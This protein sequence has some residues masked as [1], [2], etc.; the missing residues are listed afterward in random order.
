MRYKIITVMG[1]II[2]YLKEY[3]I[4]TLAEAPFNEVDNLVLSYLAYFRLADIVPAPKEHRRITASEA[5]KMYLAAYGNSQE[6]VNADVFRA[7]AASRR[8]RNAGLSC[9]T[10][11]FR[12]GTTQFAALRVTLDDGTEYLT[13][14]GSDNTLTSWQEAFAVSYEQTPAQKMAA[15]WL[16]RVFPEDMGQQVLLG[17]HSKGGNMALYAATACRPEK[18]RRITN[19][20]LNDSPGLTPCLYGPASYEELKGRIVRI[21]PQYSLIGQ[22]FEH[23]KP[24]RIVRCSTE[25][26]HQH[27]PLF[28]QTEED[29]FVTTEHLSE[30]SRRLALTL[31]RWVAS[32][33]FQ[34][35]Q[36][37]TRDFFQALRAFRSAG[38]AA[39]PEAAADNGNKISAAAESGQTCEPAGSNSE[40]QGAA[41]SVNR[42]GAA[43]SN[44]QQGTAQ[45]VNKAGAAGTSGQ[46]GAAQTVKKAGAAGSNS[47]RQG[48]CGRLRVLLRAWLR[49]DHASRRA[50]Y[51][52]AGAHY[53]TR[54]HAMK[55]RILKRN[56]KK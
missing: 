55:Q 49:A 24:D 10:E 1:N 44:G 46:Q 18:R 43:G 52:L 51:K 34:E 22:L 5:A 45:T 36:A 21:T 32:T 19:I 3:G 13:F 25:G 33:T 54:V 56:I 47:G 17:G 11:V 7:V 48:A 27:E 12:T 41:Q 53:V 29:H 6:D 31:N 26:I 42:A 28:W 4:H 20:Y 30:K 9:Y 40:R 38:G 16:D 50:V 35:R 23:E 14:R 37:F 2:T 8:F 15:V 39:V